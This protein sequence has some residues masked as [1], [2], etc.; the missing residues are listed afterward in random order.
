[1][2]E[3]HISAEGA[4]K[5]GMIY[6]VFMWFL[7]QHESRHGRLKLHEHGSNMAVWIVESR[8]DK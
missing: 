6:V 8:D 4:R 7:W 5:M 3:D 1:M 2:M